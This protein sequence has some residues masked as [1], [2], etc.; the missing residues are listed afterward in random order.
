MAKILHYVD[1]IEEHQKKKSNLNENLNLRLQRSLSWL[2]R[3]ESL[4][5]DGIL[6]ESFILYWVSFNSIYS[7]E[8]K[9][10]PN[11]SDK[12][13]FFDYFVTI[14]SLDTGKIIYNAVW[15]SFSGSIRSL[16]KNKKAFQPYWESLVE[17]DNLWE[18]KFKRSEK[19]FIFAVNRQDTIMILC[20]LFDRMYV[21]RN[22]IVH[23]G[24]TRNSPQNRPQVRD[25]ANIMAF[26]V[27]L[28]IHLMMNNPETDWPR[29]FYPVSS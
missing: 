25:S 24:V 2:K 5:D 13:V 22:Q 28:F 16:I 20:I 23:G 9:Y 19:E 11:S 17:D 18:N 12:D 1:L 27:P 3:S 29:P 4:Y 15:N 7:A 26:L 8:R 10:K 6:D 21:L 14:N